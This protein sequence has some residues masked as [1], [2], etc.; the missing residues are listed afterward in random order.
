VD[1][2]PNLCRLL[3]MLLREHGH[4]ARYVLSGED[5]LTA[6]AE[7]VPDLALL[8][9]N[10][11]GMDGMET[12][13][14]LKRQAPELQVVIMSA[15]GDLSV[16]V[17]AMKQGAVDFLSKPFDNKALLSTIDTHLA[18]RS[19]APPDSPLL[20]GQSPT[21]LTA[22]DEARKFAPPDINV[23]L[24]GETGTGKELFAKTIHACSK[25]RNGPFVAMDCSMLAENL[26]ES[27]LFG[28]EKGA[29]TGADTSRIGRLEL[30]QG[31]TLF[32]DEIGN[33]PLAFQA[34]MLRVLQERRMV[35]VGGRK[36]IALDV[37]LISATNV[38]VKEAVQ[39]GRFRQD[40]FYRL[41]E[42]A[43]NLPPL[44]E[45]PGDVRL[46]AERFVATYAKAFQAPVAS[47]SPEALRTLESHPWP[48]NVRELENAM[49]SAVV[50]AADIMRREDLPPEIQGECAAPAASAPASAPIGRR[51]R[52]LVEIEYELDALGV[53]LKAIGAQA[54]ERAESQ[55]LQDLSKRVRVAGS[56][57][58]KM[59]NVDPK[60]LRT[61]L[62]KYGL[63]TH[64]IS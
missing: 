40:L 22:V 61:K 56:R 55:V 51:Q 15:V 17:R 29:F 49:K 8:D 31:G 48:G 1:D 52:L 24:L 2:E 36:T 12:L 25:R 14:R 53:D 44:R 57:L 54:A 4:R 16:A 34:K 60:T 28:Y 18:N 38:N 39:A 7:H 58:A 45:R 35:R 26:F 21:F 33:L 20:I 46:L 19:E 37:R 63:E 42:V 11:T 41:Q 62:R 59:V 50:R 6:A 47:I 5:A 13:R 64:G 23:L 3:T 27:E 43:I 30:A 10:M 32:L 9:L